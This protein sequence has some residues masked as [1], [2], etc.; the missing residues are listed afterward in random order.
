MDSPT[1]AK[2]AALGAIVRRNKI[3][4]TMRAPASEDGASLLTGVTPVIGKNPC[5][6]SE[7]TSG[8]AVLKAWRP[9]ASA[10]AVFR[11]CS[12]LRPISCAGLGRTLSVYR[13]PESDWANRVTCQHTVQRSGTADVPVYVRVIQ[14]DGHQ[15]WSS[16]ID[17]IA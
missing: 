4:A 5:W 3:A 13:L 8:G 10:F 15:A 9:S 11:W 16:P 6:R 17:L 1:A 7:N 2:L 12:T 14:A